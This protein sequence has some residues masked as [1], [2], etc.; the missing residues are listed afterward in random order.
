V[1]DRNVIHF[2]AGEPLITEYSYKH[3]V[4]A[5]RGLLL[6]AGWRVRHVFMGKEQP[7]RLWLCEPVG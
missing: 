4:N 2:A 5:M 3:T 1:L 6:A 7:M